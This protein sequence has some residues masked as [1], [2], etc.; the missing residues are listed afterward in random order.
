MT[1]AIHGRIRVNL[2]VKKLKNNG[3]IAIPTDTIY[4]LSCLP[5]NAHKLI[6]LKNRTNNKGLILIANDLQYFTKYINI[7]TINMLKKKYQQTTSPTT[8]IVHSK[9]NIT[10]GVKQ[11]IAVRLVDNKLITMICKLTNSAIISSSVNISGKNNAKTIVKLKVYFGN[12]IDYII[13]PNN[14]NK[15]SVI[16]NL[17]T[18]KKVRI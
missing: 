9:K 8:F 1:N 3:I 16:I 4:G 5:N 10:F 6:K 17:I 13:A 18:N 14:C 2:A 15:P 11:T 12:K 7:E